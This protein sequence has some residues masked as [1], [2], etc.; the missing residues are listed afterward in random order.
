MILILAGLCLGFV[1][2]TT[3][4]WPL[5]IDLVV[6]GLCVLLSVPYVAL[7]KEELSVSSTLKGKCVTGAMAGALSFIIMFIWC[8]LSISIWWYFLSLV[9]GIIACFIPCG[10]SLS[11]LLLEN[12]GLVPALPNWASIILVAIDLICIIMYIQAFSMRRRR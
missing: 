11:A 7:T 6:F 5:Y 9:I 12:I 4:T 3:A 1:Y 10:F 2:I 8:G